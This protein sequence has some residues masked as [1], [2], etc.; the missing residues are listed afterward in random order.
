MKNFLLIILIGK[1][2]FVFFKC[3]TEE[4]FDVFLKS[5]TYSDIVRYD[6]D[7]KK[8]ELFFLVSKFSG[9]FM[10]IKDYEDTLSKNYLTA[11][12]LE[13]GE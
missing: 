13:K 5:L 9:L 10:T 7:S 11:K 8:M 12:K 2:L 6:E 4:S 3:E 1:T